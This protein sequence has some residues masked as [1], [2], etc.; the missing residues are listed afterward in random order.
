MNTMRCL[1]VDVSMD[2]NALVHAVSLMVLLLLF[3]FNW[4]IK[5][6]YSFHDVLAHDHSIHF[7]F[8]FYLVL[9]VFAVVSMNIILDYVSYTGMKHRTSR[10]DLLLGMRSYL[11]FALI[12]PTLA[13]FLGRWLNPERKIKK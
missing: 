3:L 12:F 13:V 1:S 2:V 4:E 8:S 7:Y 6:T 5:E 9:G 11:S 10:R